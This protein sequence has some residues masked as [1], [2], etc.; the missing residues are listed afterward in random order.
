MNYYGNNDFREYLAH[1]GVLGMKWGV[2]RYQP[3]SLIPRK[4]GKRGKE[5]IK[6]NSTF[7][8]K[9]KLNRADQDSANILAKTMKSTYKYDK[10]ASK[11][12]KLKSKGKTKRAAK[13]EI[14]ALQQKKDIN[15]YKKLQNKIKDYTKMVISEASRKGL[16]VSS[17]E[18]IRSG[19]AWKTYASYKVDGLEGILAKELINYRRY[20]GQY[21]TKTSDGRVISQTPSYIKGLKYSVKK[22]K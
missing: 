5:L 4:S 6:G 17:K 10:Y 21:N 8:Y 1:H 19:E 16:K 7:K 14:K 15:S 22:K 3:Y 2:R 20:S 11:A 12:K 9:R 18:K 13:Y